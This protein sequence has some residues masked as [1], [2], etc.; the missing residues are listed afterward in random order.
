MVCACPKPQLPHLKNTQQAPLTQPWG[1]DAVSP[2]PGTQYRET[3]TRLLLCIWVLAACRV[4]ASL[5][6][7]EVP[8]VWEARYGARS[9][10]GKTEARG[11]KAAWRVKRQGWDYSSAP[12]PPR[13]P[14]TRFW[15]TLLCDNLE[16]AGL[17]PTPGNGRTDGRLGSSAPQPC[18]RDGPGGGSKG[19]PSCSGDRAHQLSRQ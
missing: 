2:V 1:R 13:T 3:N 5:L 8:V 15:H 16:E 12:P 6:T 18:S 9:V 4:P 10:D 11:Y 7:A 17:E 14:K 19:P